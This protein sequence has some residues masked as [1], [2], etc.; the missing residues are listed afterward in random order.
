MA[1][2]VAV[3]PRQVAGDAP[4][5]VLV[6]GVVGAVD[7]K[8]LERSEVGF[9]GIEPAGVGRCVGRLD[10]VVGH[11]RSQAGVLVGVEVIHHNVQ[12]GGHGVAGPQ[13]CEDGQQVA[14]GLAFAHLADETIGMDV[15]E[16]QQLL[17][18]LEPPV[19]RPEALGMAHWRPALAGQRSQFE[20][21]ALVEADDGAV[22]RAL[23]VEVEDAVFFASNSGSGDCFQVLV[24]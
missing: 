18:A 14:D 3:A 20:R 8:P 5:P 9:D 10:V 12:A 7:G 19:G 4:A 1:A 2:L 24:C 16:G 13:P 6:G 23:L 21:A 15:V 11:E 22:L 17:C